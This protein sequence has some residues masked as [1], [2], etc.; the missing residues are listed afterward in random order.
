MM[1]I[2]ELQ[3][4]LKYMNIKSISEAAGVH[5][6]SVYRLMRQGSASYRTVERLSD[7]LESLASGECDAANK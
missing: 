2:K 3:R 4:E 5:R 6:N 7:F 1:T